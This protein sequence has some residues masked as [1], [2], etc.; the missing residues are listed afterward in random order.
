[1]KKK[2]RD[3]LWARGIWF[4]NIAQGG[5]GAIPGDPDL[6]MCFN[7]RLIAIEGKSPIGGKRALQ[8]TRQALLEQNGGKYYTIR[9]WEQYQRLL[10]SE[11]IE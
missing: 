3:D 6:I 10:K 4:S 9:N 2:I 8:H 5:E 7:G 11:G 1:M